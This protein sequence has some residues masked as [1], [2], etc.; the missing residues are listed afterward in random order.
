[1]AQLLL[2]HVLPRGGRARRVA[3]MLSQWQRTPLHDEAASAELRRR[4]EHGWF[5]REEALPLL[6]RQLDRLRASGFDVGRATTTVALAKLFEMQLPEEA[7]ALLAELTA[8]G[9]LPHGPHY[10]LL[11][12]AC[13][14]AAPAPRLD[15]YRE[16]LAGLDAGGLTAAPEGG[17]GGGGG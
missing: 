7:H 2:K 17:G 14:A 15:L 8:A 5:L 11:L 10:A 4:V 12:G 3:D 9:V 1:M 6:R 13:A 16:V